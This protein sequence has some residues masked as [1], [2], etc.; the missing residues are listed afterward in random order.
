[1]SRY[2]EGIVTG[3]S[4]EVHGAPERPRATGGRRLTSAVNWSRGDLG[5]RAGGG[6]LL[7]PPVHKKTHLV[8]VELF[9]HFF[10]QTVKIMIVI[11]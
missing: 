2:E 4:Q 3:R 8:M 1:M 7:Y 9:Y 11:S 6:G 5:S 10:Q